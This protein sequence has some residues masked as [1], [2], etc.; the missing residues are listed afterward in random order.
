MGYGH[1]LDPRRRIIAA[2][3]AVALARE[4]DRRFEVSASSAVNLVRRWRETGSLAP[5]QIGGQKKRRLS[6]YED[7]LHEV[8][9]AM[10]GITLSELQSRLAAGAAF[11]AHV[12]PV[13]VPSLRPGDI[14][15]MDNL[16][17]HEVEGVRKAIKRKAIKTAGA[18]PP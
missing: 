4:A 7:W 10:P 14:V 2:V 18:L 17:S 3:E 8:M 12:E 15:I 9:A 16:P 13:L 5:G 1:S 6:G 11:K